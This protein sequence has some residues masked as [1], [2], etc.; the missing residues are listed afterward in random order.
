MKLIVIVTAGVNAN[1]A[2][3]FFPKLE[4]SFCS[5]RVHCT[6]LL[7]FILSYAPNQA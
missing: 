1:I 3:Y 5:F 2:S 7:Y 6:M 4:W